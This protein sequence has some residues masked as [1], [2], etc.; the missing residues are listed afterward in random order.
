MAAVNAKAKVAANRAA[1]G[2]LAQAAHRVPLLPNRQVVQV[3]AVCPH[4]RNT[5][6]AGVADKGVVIPAKAGMMWLV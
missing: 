6:P 5:A 4:R 3:A 1:A 2:N